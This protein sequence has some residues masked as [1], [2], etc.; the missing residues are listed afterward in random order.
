MR[1][2]VS[3]SSAASSESSSQPV[4]L[5]LYFRAQRGR[6]LASQSAA[7]DEMTAGRPQLHVHERAIIQQGSA[8]DGEIFCSSFS[9]FKN[10]EGGER[11]K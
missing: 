4:L 7:D 10:T 1:I 5:F 9:V 2:N 8:A 3:V 11:A 6:L